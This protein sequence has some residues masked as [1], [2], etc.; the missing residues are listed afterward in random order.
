MFSLVGKR[1]NNLTARDENVILKA[2]I[3]SDQRPG[4]SD[5]PR[6]LATQ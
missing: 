4:A 2:Q 6:P 3:L 1:F 5:S